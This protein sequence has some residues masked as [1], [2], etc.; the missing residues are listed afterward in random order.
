MEILDPIAT[1]ALDL[2]GQRVIVELGKPIQVGDDFQC[3]FAIRGGPREWSDHVMGVDSVQALQ[4]AM[5]RVGFCLEA[6]PTSEGTLTWLGEEA[7]KGG[8]D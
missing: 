2:G 6:L 8:F 1:R 7:P 4:L 5:R 3:A